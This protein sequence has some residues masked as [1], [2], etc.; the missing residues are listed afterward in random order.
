[1]LTFL[2]ASMMLLGG[3]V[4]GPAERMFVGAAEHFVESVG[5]EYVEYV[6]ADESLSAAGKELRKANVESFRAAVEARRNALD[7]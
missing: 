2:M 4:H 1:M 5:P 3:C 7:N 6:E